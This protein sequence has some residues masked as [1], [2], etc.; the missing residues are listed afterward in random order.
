MNGLFL[1][2]APRVQNKFIRV[3][4][5]NYMSPLPEFCYVRRCREGIAIDILK[6][7]WDAGNC[8][9]LQRFVEIDKHAILISDA[10]CFSMM[11][12]YRRHLFS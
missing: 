2:L 5:Y 7:F 9:S 4:R 1:R 8:S 11:G 3:G 6:K 10:G 12:V